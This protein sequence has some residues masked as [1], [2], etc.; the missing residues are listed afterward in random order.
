MNIGTP[1]TFHTTERGRPLERAA[2]VSELDSDGFVHLTVF[3]RPIAD[4]Q[5]KGGHLLTNELS[6]AYFTEAP[7]AA[8]A[9]RWCGPAIS[10]AKV[11]DGLLK[12][13]APINS[14]GPDVVIVPPSKDKKN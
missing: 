1:V 2:I 12:R 5:A 3:A 7:S 8:Y 13:L 14:Q 4:I 9:G 6:V 10:P 11:P